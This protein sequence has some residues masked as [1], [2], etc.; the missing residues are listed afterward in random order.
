M[1]LPSNPSLNILRSFKFQHRFRSLQGK[2]SCNPAKNI[3]NEIGK[4]SKIE[5]DKKSLIPTF[6]HFL[7]A[8]AKV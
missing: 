4:S 3:W 1:S 8:I 7:T 2:Q 5:K 6:A